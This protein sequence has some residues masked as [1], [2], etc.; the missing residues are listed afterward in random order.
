[1]FSNTYF[2]KDI[3]FNPFKEGKSQ[4]ILGMNRLES[5]DRERE[6]ENEYKMNKL[7]Y[8]S[9]KPKEKFQ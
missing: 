6:R 7:N 2:S 1:M 9:I 3:P 5:K 4:A 8:S